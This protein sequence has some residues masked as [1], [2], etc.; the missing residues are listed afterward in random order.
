MKHEKILNNK[1]LITT[2]KEPYVALGPMKPHLKK[3][4]HNQ[5]KGSYASKENFKNGGNKK[6]YDSGK[7]NEIKAKFYGNY[8]FYK[9]YGHKEVDCFR[10]KKNQSEKGF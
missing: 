2:P 9:R 7:S 10:K 1:V 8:I 3:K 4:N 6:N 5:K